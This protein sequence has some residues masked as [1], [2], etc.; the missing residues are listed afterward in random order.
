MK[1]TGSYAAKSTA[2]CSSIINSLNLIFKESSDGIAFKDK[3]LVYREANQ[4]FCKIF[5]IEKYEDI[6]G[7]A[8]FSK[9]SDKNMELIQQISN[10]IIDEKQPINYTMAFEYTD[11]QNRILNIT[12]SPVNYNDEFLG[13]V[14][15]VKDITSEEN[16]KE[17]FVSK[18]FQLKSFFENIP[19]LIYMQDDRGKY[20]AGTK[21]AL[22]FVKN[23]Y[24]AFT[25]I[26]IDWTKNKPKE[27]DNNY[28]IE[29]R[30]TIVRE[31]RLI[32]YEG[33]PHWYK[34]YKVPINNLDGSIAGVITVA[35]NTD[36]EKQLQ[37]QRETFVASI[38]HDLKNPTIAQIRGLELLLKGEFGE[39]NYDQ[40]LLIE[41]VLDSCRYMNGMLST[42]LATYRN[43]DGAAK[44]ELAEFS[45]PDLVMECVSEMIYV[46]K[47][48]NIEISVDLKSQYELINADRV[49]LKRVIMNLLSNGIKYAYKDS[50][51]KLKVFNEN[52]KTCFEFEN[53]SPYIPP[54]KQKS[55]FAQYVTFASAHKELGIGLGLYTSQKIIEAHNGSIYVISSKENKNTFGFKIPTT[56]NIDC[57]DKNI[58]L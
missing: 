2:K 42:L 45:F 51:L 28:V 54:N 36:A 23:G 27:T 26:H 43:F 3:N 33:T 52:Q 24:D 4:A 57:F 13:I 18:H 50:T 25:G 15:I 46:A 34:I 19:M 47:D 21:P 55:I 8:N 30:K 31:K 48:K 39:V 41:M 5:K 35:N 29:K 49:Q 17:N 11:G 53:N 16:I 14:S 10:T 1:T 58:C 32:D 12:S 6:I 56:Q 22:N 40:K 9:L 38:G 44:V 37:T 20:I 7:H